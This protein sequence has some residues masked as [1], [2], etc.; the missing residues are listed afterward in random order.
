MPV[1]KD[2]STPIHNKHLNVVARPTTDIECADDTLLIARTT[3][4]LTNLL[5]T[6]EKHAK[7]H[8]M[9]LNR[10]KPSTS[11]TLDITIP[12]C[13]SKVDRKSRPQRK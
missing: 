7:L 4:Q 12:N 13:I 6:L 2:E 8:G 10:E 1:Y 5:H 3:T 11:S 9:H